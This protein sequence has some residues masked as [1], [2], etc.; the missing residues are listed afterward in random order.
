MKVRCIKEFHSLL[1]PKADY[2]VLGKTYYVSMARYSVVWDGKEPMYYKLHGI[3][4][5]V[6]TERFEII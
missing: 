6:K 3:E 4:E 5:W 2:G 1:N